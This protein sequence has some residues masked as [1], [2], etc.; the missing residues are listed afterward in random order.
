MDRMTRAVIELTGDISTAMPRMSGLIEDCAY[1]REYNL[2]SFSVKGMSVMV[3]S[4]KITESLLD[5]DIEG[6]LR[7]LKKHFDEKLTDTL[8]V[9][10][11]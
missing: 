3:E 10:G 2:M 11:H 8:S 5:E 1:N 6:A 7:F 9:E 4:N